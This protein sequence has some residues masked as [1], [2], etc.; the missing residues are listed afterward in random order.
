M[1]IGPQ[2]GRVERARAALMGRTHRRYTAHRHVHVGM[3]ADISRAYAT[4]PWTEQGRVL[5]Y[6]NEANVQQGAFD[7]AHFTLLA[8]SSYHSPAQVVCSPPRS[9]AGADCS[10]PLYGSPA[11]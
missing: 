6:F 9:G 11:A 4:R 1:A 2:N 3:R 10:A 5:S 8:V 7:R